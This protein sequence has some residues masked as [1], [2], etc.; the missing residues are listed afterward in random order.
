MGISFGPGGWTTIANEMRVRGFEIVAKD[1]PNAARNKYQQMEK[2]LH[3]VAEGVRLDCGTIVHATTGKTMTK[4]VNCDDY[5]GEWVARKGHNAYCRFV[6]MRA[7]KDI[8]FYL[9]TLGHGSILNFD[10]HFERL[11]G[12]V[13]L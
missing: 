6:T 1:P 3:A 10:F 2:A 8:L 9:Q 11:C 4:C 12:L 5:L 7:Q 13:R